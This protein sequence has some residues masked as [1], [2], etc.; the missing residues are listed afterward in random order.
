MTL[1]LTHRESAAVL[2]GLRMLQQCIELPKDIHR[3]ATADGRLRLL[4]DDETDRLC[5]RL[6]VG[7][8]C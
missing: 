2:A 5:A 3:I 6:H 4:R 1:R 8:K 7:M